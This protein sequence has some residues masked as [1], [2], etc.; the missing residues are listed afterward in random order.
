MERRVQ[1]L[2][3]SNRHDLPDEVRGAIR[4]SV[5]VEECTL[6]SV[7]RSIG[8]SGRTLSRRLREHGTTFRDLREEMRFDA[9]CQLI[10]QTRMTATEVAST[11]GY[12]DASAFSRAFERWSGTTPSKWRALQAGMRARRRPA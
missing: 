1:E 9:A 6:Q 3:A 4:R 5:S 7:A 12:S 2:V 11:L 10:A 8:I